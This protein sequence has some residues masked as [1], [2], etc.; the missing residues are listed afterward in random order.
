MR[1]LLVKA[2]NNRF[3]ITASLEGGRK[4]NGNFGSEAGHRERAL[5]VVLD[6]AWAQGCN[7]K[8]KT[9]KGLDRSA[10]TL[11][12]ILTDYFAVECLPYRTWTREH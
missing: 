4:N 5:D 12:P 8:N 1:S 2:R 9:Q 7:T 6:F 3:N 10:D 11:L